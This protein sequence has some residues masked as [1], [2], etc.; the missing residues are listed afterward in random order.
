VAWISLDDGKANAL[1]LDEFESLSQ[2]LEQVAQSDAPAAVLTGRAGFFSAGLNLKVLPQ[3]EAEPLMKTLHRF[4]QVVGDQLFLFPKP[5]V[6][7]VTGH[8]IAA[9][10][11]LAL[12]C[13]ARF[14]ADGP[15][16]FGL[17]EVPG[18]MPVP[19]FGVELMRA[20]VSAQHLSR[21]VTQGQ[22]LSPPEVLA[23]GIADAVVGA[24]SLAAVAQQRALQLAEL[25]LQP[26][27]QTKLKVRGPAAAFARNGLAAE[28]DALGRALGQ[29]G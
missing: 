28:L 21:L 2:A 14:F 22:M 25:P 12:A 1:A 4:A 10:A 23:H 26:Y 20:A 7:A 9:G 5:L 19:Q 6:A 29:R 8:A 24:E 17:N 27:T 18:G 13:D 11:M 15:F 16:K 3:L